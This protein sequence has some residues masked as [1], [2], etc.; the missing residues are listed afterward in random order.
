MMKRTPL[1]LLAAV[2]IAV[3]VLRS[4]A[5][6]PL[7]AERN[8]TPPKITFLERIKLG[9]SVTITDKDGRY[10]IGMFENMS[11]PLAH[12]IVEIGKDYLV[13][14]DV[15]GVTDTVIPVYSIKA[16][17]VLRVGGKQHGD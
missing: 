2:V 17:R 11:N 6:L 7:E 8:N 13:V 12:N 4:F 1:F 9:Q 15:V 10:E 5:A 14:R 3:A 16:I